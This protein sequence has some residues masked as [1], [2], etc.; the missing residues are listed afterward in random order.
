M[1]AV[2]IRDI[3]FSYDKQPFIEGLSAGFK[4][5]AVTSIVGPNGCGKSTLVKL[6]DGLQAPQAGAVFIDGLAT[7]SMRG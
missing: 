2:D 1:T 4:P 5:G 6:I 3:S 7:L